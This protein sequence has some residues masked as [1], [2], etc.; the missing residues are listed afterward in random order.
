MTYTLAHAQTGSHMLTHTRARTGSGPAGVL[1]AGVK[2]NLKEP[3]GK[4]AGIHGG[5]YEKEVKKEH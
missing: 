1:V 5:V 2:F 3:Y 4:G